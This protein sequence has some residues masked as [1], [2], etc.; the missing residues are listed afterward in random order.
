MRLFLCFAF[1]RSYEQESDEFWQGL[2]DK[3]QSLAILPLKTMRY[4]E[5]PSVDKAWN[6]IGRHL[7]QAIEQQS[8]AYG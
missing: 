3:N 8:K 1:S 7:R 5:T 6:N 4:P 2:A